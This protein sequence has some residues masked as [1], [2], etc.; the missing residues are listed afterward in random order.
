MPYFAY[1]RVIS[2]EE[3]NA[4]GNTYFSQYVKWQGHCREMF[5]KA[6][7][8]WVVRELGSRYALV[9]TEVACNYLQE[10]EA[11]DE[12][13]L[14]LYSSATAQNRMNLEFEYWR[15]GSSADQDELV[16]R[17]HQQLAWLERREDGQMHPRPV[18]PRLLYA[19]DE[20]IE[21][22]YAA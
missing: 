13:C 1:R 12:L 6:T 8:D 10:T 7:A 21:S 3:T 4:T 22:K 5:L 19:I 14:H 20:Y 2:L 18:P 9:T 17:G 15:L 16:A 11:F